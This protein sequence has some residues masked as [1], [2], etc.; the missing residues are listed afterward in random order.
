LDQGAPPTAPAGGAKPGTEQEETIVD[1]LSAA[2]RH[3]EQTHPT[4]AGIVGSVI[5]A[6][7]RMG[8]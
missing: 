4:I 6:L 7:S 1:R 5:N 2:Q 8:I 3:F